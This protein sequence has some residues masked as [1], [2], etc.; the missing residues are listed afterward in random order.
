MTVEPVQH[1]LFRLI[2]DQLA[3]V[4]RPYLAGLARYPLPLA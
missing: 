3:P 1:P 2:S 4:V